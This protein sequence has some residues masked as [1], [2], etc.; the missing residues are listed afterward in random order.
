MSA[1]ISQEEVD[2]AQRAWGAAVAGTDVEALM[3]LYDLSDLLFKPT[4]SA[5]IRTDA[6]GTRSYFVGSAE[7]PEDVGFLKRPVVDVRF[8]SSRGIQLTADCSSAHDMGH[9]S[10]VRPDGSA[11]EADYTFIYRKVAGKLL[12]ALHHSSFTVTP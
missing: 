7:R 8:A 11:L 4:A 3:A 6:A 9:Y 5:S 1:K 2:Q 12:I 10:F